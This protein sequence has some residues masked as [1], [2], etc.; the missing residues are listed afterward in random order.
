M[1]WQM[2]L[3]RGWLCTQGEINGKLLV[4]VHSAYGTSY[5]KKIHENTKK[6]PQLKMIEIVA[7]LFILSIGSGNKNCY[8]ICEACFGAL[9][10]IRALKHVSNCWM[11]LPIFF[12]F[13][14]HIYSSRITSNSDIIIYL[15]RKSKKKNR[16][17]QEI[18][19]KKQCHFGP[20]L[21]SI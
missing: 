8:L 10:E 12:D 21:K 17:N 1:L 15:Q 20:K 4:F 5:R 9:W 3:L 18:H 19:K 2:L 13:I 14:F 16:K 11:K 7:L 6:E